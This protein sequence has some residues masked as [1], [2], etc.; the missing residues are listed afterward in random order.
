MDKLTTVIFLVEASFKIIAY[1]FVIN[2]KN[3]Y[4]RQSEN[5]FDFCVL[6]FSLPNLISVEN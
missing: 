6:V 2:G 5:I 1:G 4:L 3:S